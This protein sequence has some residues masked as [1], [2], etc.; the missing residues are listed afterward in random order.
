[1]NEGVG[2]SSTVLSCVSA[3]LLE[4][5]EGHG[6]CRPAPPAQSPVVRRLQLPLPPLRP[7]I[8]SDVSRWA[9]QLAT[10]RPVVLSGK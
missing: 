1:M 2:R 3:A 5:R 9:P 10:E 7:H 4:E 8:R 6:P